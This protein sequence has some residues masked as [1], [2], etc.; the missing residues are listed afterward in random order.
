MPQPK[1]VHTKKRAKVDAR[2][3]KRREWRLRD[4]QRQA[5]RH[6]RAIERAVAD[7]GLEQ[8]VGRALERKL[9]AGH[10]LMTKIF[11]VMFP[12]LFGCETYPELSRVMGWDKNLPGRLLG[13]MPKRKWIQKLRAL[14]QDVLETLWERV[15]GM[16]ESTRSR[17]QWTWVLDST[18]LRKYG[19]KFGLVKPVFSNQDK[20]KGPGIEVVLLAVVIGD[21]KLIV[22]LDFEI[23]RPDPEGAG[24]PCLNKLEWTA[25]MLDRNL[26]AFE[27][28]GLELPPPLV[29]A[30]A[31]FADSHLMK[32]VRERWKGTLLVEGKSNFVFELDEQRRL[33]A[34]SLLETPGRWRRSEQLPKDVRYV[35]LQAKSKTFGPVTL[36]IVDEPKEKELYY[37]LCLSTDISSTRLWRAFARRNWVEWCFRTL[38]TLLKTDKCQFVTEDAYYGHVAMRI[39]ALLVLG[40]A[41]RRVLRGRTTIEKAIFGIKHH[42]RTLDSQF[43]EFEPLSCEQTLK[44][45]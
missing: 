20:R 25:K 13:A 45:A 35:R 38:K 9:K 40:Y 29:A 44:R 34:K 33:D 8:T 1:G 37:L 11:G 18:V 4:Q 12:V 23:R 43:I 41:T 6:L 2:R 26:E 17:W 10:K 7:L 3:R 28:R 42:W 27:Q 30:D 32:H 24:R 31:W 22:P 21:G 15:K 5:G 16:S 14:G 36:T 39:M 19:E